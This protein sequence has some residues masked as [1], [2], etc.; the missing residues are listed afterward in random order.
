MVDTWRAIIAD[1]QNSWVMF[2]HGTRLVLMEP[3]EDLQAQARKIMAEQ[4]PVIPGTPA[5]DFTVIKLNK[6]P[7]WL[8]Y[9]NIPGVLNYVG[10]DELEEE[11]TDDPVALHVVIGYIGRDKRQKDAE[12]LNIV[13]VEEKKSQLR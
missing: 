1:E 5:G 12:A 9:Y 6:Y 11:G 10:P 3:W 8:V 13:H 4:G 2:E 7:G